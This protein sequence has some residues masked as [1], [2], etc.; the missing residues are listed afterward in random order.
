MGRA[1][2]QRRRGRFVAALLI[3]VAGLLALSLALL[4]E[5]G[6]PHVWMGAGGLALWGHASRHVIESVVIAIAVAAGLSAGV[7]MLARRAALALA[8]MWIA[9]ALAVCVWT[10]HEAAAVWEVLQWRFAR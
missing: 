5:V 3:T 1:R 7:V 2:R 4:T 9:W 6:T 10:P 8:A